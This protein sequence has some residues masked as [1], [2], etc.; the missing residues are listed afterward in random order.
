MPVNIYPNP[1]SSTTLLEI[2]A[3]LDTE[4]K[5]YNSLGQKV[6]S[7]E[8]KESPVTIE[9]GNLPAGVY[10]LYVSQGNKMAGVTKLVITD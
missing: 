4:V 9:R 8:V 2:N 7:V 6:Q 5:I 1:F 10:F 3:T